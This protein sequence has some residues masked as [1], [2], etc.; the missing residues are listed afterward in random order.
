MASAS[1]L[2]QA[3][4]KQALL[5]LRDLTVE[6]K[7]GVSALAN[8]SLDITRGE[9]VVL[10]GTSG[11]GKSTLLRTINGLVSATHGSVLLADLPPPPYR[12]AVLREH[13]RR[14]AM[15]F[16]HHHLIGR[17]TVLANVLMGALGSRPVWRSLFPWQRQDRLKALACLERVGLLDLALS[18]ADQLSGGQQ[19]RVGI[20]RCL[21]QSPRLLLADEPVASLDP[22]TARGVLELLRNICK[23]DGL[24]AIVSLHQLDLA[25]R[26]ADRI[27]GLSNG[28]VV[29]DK[30][31]H[32]FNDSAL[33]NIYRDRAESSSHSHAAHS[34]NF[35]LELVSS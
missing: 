9:F 15:V 31:G 5:Q 4:S 12:A 23:H 3:A 26:F 34:S 30:D 28:R 11:A 20:A 10:L 1:T 22:V 6:Y 24:T 25:K 35:H 29:F 19:Q 13:R 21:M 33:A 17:Q 16:Q 2:H 27:V 14:T 32:E 8:C 7:P 18:R